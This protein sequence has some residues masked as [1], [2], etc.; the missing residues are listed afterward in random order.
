MKIKIL[1]DGLYNDITRSS[2]QCKAG[3]EL[4]T[5]PAY[6]NVLVND[7]FAEHI[8][9][10]EPEPTRKARKTGKNKDARAESKTPNLFIG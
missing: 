1:Q 5:G 7:G 4:D 10:I 8:E 9:E 2:V 6:A 3:D